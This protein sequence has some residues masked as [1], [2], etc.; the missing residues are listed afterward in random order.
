[1]VVPKER[2]EKSNR[3]NQWYPNSDMGG[4]QGAR[5][6]FEPFGDYLLRL[7]FMEK[8]DT[9][10]ID[11]A[12]VVIDS[13]KLSFTGRLDYNNLCFLTTDHRGINRV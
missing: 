1:M 2:Y 7:S 13:G 8:D 4:T 10:I 6:S 12:V 9:Y 5:L 11:G 3:A